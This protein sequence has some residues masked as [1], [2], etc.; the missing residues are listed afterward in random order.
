[1]F[2][3]LGNLFLI[4]ALLAATGAHWGVLQS[5]AWT[6]M[7]AGNLSNE[8]FC[9]AVQNTFNGKRPCELCKSIQAGK[10]SE[11]QNELPAPVIKKLEYLNQ[12]P[13][14]VFPAPTAFELLPAQT[15]FPDSINHTPP[16]PP[17]RALV[18][19]G[20]RA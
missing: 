19:S 9:D 18:A 4:L 11:H 14:F 5:V 17:P 1:M 15:D 7:L 12:A 8:S 6:T 16:S 2:K 3:R 20:I 10:K 13:R